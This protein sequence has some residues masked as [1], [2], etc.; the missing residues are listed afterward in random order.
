MFAVVVSK[1]RTHYFTQFVLSD[2]YLERR[3]V[4]QSVDRFYRYFP[5][6][7]SVRGER[8]S[9]R[10]ATARIK[11]LKNKHYW[12]PAF[13]L[14]GITPNERALRRQ[15]KERLPEEIGYVSRYNL[16]FLTPCWHRL[17]CKVSPRA[18]RVWFL[19]QTSGFVMTLL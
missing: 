6:E 8:W 10:E 17:R 15:Y 11:Y 9:I 2:V 12:M 1:L 13:N 14:E 5:P 3:F 18:D 7:D 16:T 4:I 19:V